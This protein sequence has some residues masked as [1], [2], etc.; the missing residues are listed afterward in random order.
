M[1]ETFEI[2]FRPK[3]AQFWIA[4]DI[5]VDDEGYYTISRK[6]GKP[7]EPGSLPYAAEILRSLARLMEPEVKSGFARTYKPLIFEAK[8]NAKKGS[9]FSIEVE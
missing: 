5:E 7:L 2:I 8:D 1:A 9:S 3:Y 6:S 4:L